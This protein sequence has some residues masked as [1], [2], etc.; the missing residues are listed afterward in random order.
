MDEIKYRKYFSRSG[1]VYEEP[2]SD[3]QEPFTGWRKNG[4]PLGRTR[5][6]SIRNLK[7]IL[8]K[9]GNTKNAVD[10]VF[11]LE[12]NLNFYEYEGRAVVD[13]GD[14][15]HFS[16]EIE[17]TEPRLELPEDIILDILEKPKSEE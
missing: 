12:H 5:Y 16:A 11:N 4:K 3:L 13:L 6:V 7:A 1:S 14:K 15:L 17:D 8:N 10:Y 2:F 9:F